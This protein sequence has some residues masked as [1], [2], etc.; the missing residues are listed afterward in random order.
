MSGTPEEYDAIVIGSGEAGKWMA[1][2]LGSQGQHVI[3]IEDKR[4][5]EPAP[6]SPAFPART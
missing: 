2:H 5:G 6:T 4:I 3:N 1:W